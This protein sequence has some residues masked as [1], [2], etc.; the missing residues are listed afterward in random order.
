[1]ACKGWRDLICHKIHHR[2]GD[3]FPAMRLLWFGPDAVLLQHWA[4]FERR[5]RGLRHAGSPSVG[6]P[7]SHPQEAV[8]SH[9]LKQVLE[10]F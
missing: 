7:A 5:V 1:M 2:V 6:R 3:L 10:S 8:G 4:P 9:W